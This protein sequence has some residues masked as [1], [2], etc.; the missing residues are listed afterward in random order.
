[1]S[2]SGSLMMESMGMPI[3]RNPD[4]D[5]APVGPPVLPP[6]SPGQLQAL[7]ALKQLPKCLV[8]MRVIVVHFDI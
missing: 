3:I 6:L 2:R 4:P 7:E 8:V 1:M 5:M